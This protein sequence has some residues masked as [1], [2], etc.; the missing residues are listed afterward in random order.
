LFQKGRIIHEKYPNRGY[1]IYSSGLDPEFPMRRN[2]SFGMS[3]CGKAN[4]NH[5]KTEEESLKTI[6]MS[7]L[8][9]VVHIDFID[10]LKQYLKLLSMSPFLYHL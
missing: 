4:K 2:V 10:I 5:D 6:F 3:F 7:S 9:G 1:N 8:T